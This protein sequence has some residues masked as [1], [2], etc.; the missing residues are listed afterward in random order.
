MRGVGSESALSTK[1]LKQN[2]PEIARLE[3]AKNRI[4]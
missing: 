4:L 1:G 3:R 2:D